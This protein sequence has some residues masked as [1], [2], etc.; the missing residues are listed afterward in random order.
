MTER[1]DPPIEP[2]PYRAGVTVIDIGDVRVA[3][4][5]SRRPYSACKHQ[6][7]HYDPSERRVWCA[8]CERDLEG[9]DAFM[10]LAENS[11]D[12]IERNNRREKELAEAEAHQ[13]RSRAVKALDHIWRSRTMAPCCPHCHK[14]L[15]PEDMLR[16]L[17]SVGVDYER[18]VRAREAQP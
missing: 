11:H 14:G 9:F 16:G 17:G 12:F 1:K 8:D 4:G 15:L 6:R 10:V 3:R 13:A 2:L 18:A 5:M 7:L